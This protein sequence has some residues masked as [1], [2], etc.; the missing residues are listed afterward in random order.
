MLRAILT[1][2]ETLRARAERGQGIVE[3]ALILAFVSI[4]A[5]A[6]L[7]LFG[8]VLQALLSQVLSALET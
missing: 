3:Y 2:L 7:I 8:P 1:Y 6:V 4:A 5:V